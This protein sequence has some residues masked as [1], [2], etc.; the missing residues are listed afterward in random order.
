MNTETVMAEEQLIR[1]ATDALIQ[2]LGIM[3][4]IRFLALKQQGR[5]ESVARHREWQTSLDEKSFFDDV[6]NSPQSG[7]AVKNGSE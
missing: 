7:H 1:L 6:F 5:M 4:T 2:K 3:E